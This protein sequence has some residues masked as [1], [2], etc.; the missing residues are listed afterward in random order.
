MINSIVDKVFCIT[1]VN[2][3]RINYIENHLKERSIDFDFFIA[4]ESKI[5]S[6]KINVKDSGNIDNRPAVS[7]TSAFVSIIEKSRISK[8]NSIAIIEDDCYFSKEWEYKFEEFYKNLPNWDILNVGYHPLQDIFSKKEF[9]NNFV[10]KPLD[11]HYTTHCMILKNT[12]FE[13]FLKI[14]EE[15]EYSIP[16]DYIF[17]EIYKKQKLRSFCPKEQIIHQLSHRDI[18]K[19]YSLKEIS[20]TSIRFKS[21][22]NV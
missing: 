3:D 17:I 8:Y 10:F 1:T 2:S 16:I 11:L 4:P 18:F 13:E 7:L 5:I 12:C 15:N 19:Q 22:I 6:E 14:S 20:E 9:F 21:Y